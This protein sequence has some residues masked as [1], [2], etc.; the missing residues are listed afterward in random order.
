MQVQFCRIYH[1]QEV[2]F[3]GEGH[4]VINILENVAHA[5]IEKELFL[6]DLAHR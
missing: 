1:L 5:C 4:L 2:L 3:T 6:T